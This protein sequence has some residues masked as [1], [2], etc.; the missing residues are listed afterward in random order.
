MRLRAL[1]RCERGQAIGEY[2]GVIVLIAAAVLVMAAFAPGIAGAIADA[3]KAALCR[4]SGA[5]CSPG[6]GAAPDNPW[7]P[8]EPC[9]RSQALAAKPDR[10]RER[11]HRLALSG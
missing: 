10:P 2:T 6:E 9:V 1:T 5:G 4:I 3:V 7:L 11:G 8:D